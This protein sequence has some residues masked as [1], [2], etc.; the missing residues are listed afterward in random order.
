MVNHE[1][2]IHERDD[3]ASDIFLLW[4]LLSLGSGLAMAEAADLLNLLY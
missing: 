1:F 2:T 3:V 4:F